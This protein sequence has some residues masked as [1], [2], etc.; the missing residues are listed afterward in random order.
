[1]RIGLRDRLNA[2]LSHQRLSVVSGKKI[3]T[4]AGRGVG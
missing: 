2:K 3:P 1:M 4:S